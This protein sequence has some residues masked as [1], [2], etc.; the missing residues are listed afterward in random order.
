MIKYNKIMSMPFLYK[1]SGKNYICDRDTGNELNNYEGEYIVGPTHLVNGKPYLMNHYSTSWTWIGINGKRRFGS[2]NEYEN[3][4]TRNIPETV[5]SEISAY[6]VCPYC[7]EQTGFTT[8]IGFKDLA[9]AES[10]HLKYYVKHK[11]DQCSNEFLINLHE[12]KITDVV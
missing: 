11:C 12:T 2:E 3:R 1:S 8:E 10:S 5:Y 4:E 7:E 9:N 6:A